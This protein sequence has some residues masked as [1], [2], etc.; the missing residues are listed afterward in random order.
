M[1]ILI[2]QSRPIL[3]NISS[4]QPSV[5]CWIFSRKNFNVYNANNPFIYFLS[6]LIDVDINVKR[7]KPVL[8]HELS[9]FNKY[10]EKTENQSRVNCRIAIVILIII[11]KI[12]SVIRLTKLLMN[13][14]D[15][16]LNNWPKHCSRFLRKNFSTKFLGI[17]LIV[18]DILIPIHSSVISF[19]I[20]F[21]PSSPNCFPMQCKYFMFLLLI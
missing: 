9:N 16:K 11:S 12:W 4:M 1:R 17:P 19:T 18:L 14:Q 5:I 21:F 8:E 2:N 13:K 3:P 6:L 15:W 10:H 20:L 7:L